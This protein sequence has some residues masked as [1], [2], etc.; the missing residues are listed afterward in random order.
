MIAEHVEENREFFKILLEV[1]SSIDVVTVENGLEAIKLLENDN[2]FDFI[3]LDIQMPVMDGIQALEKIKG[4]ENLKNIPTIALTAQ[5]ILGDKEKYMPYGFDFYITKPINES[6]L[7][8]CLE[9][10]L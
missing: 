2:N 5:A 7:F 10:F 4:N 9:S 8:S 3:F 6:V 1:C